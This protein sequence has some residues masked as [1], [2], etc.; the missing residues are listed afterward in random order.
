MFL[1]LSHKFYAIIFFKESI[2]QKNEPI[3]ACDAY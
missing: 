2:M 3:Q 1:L